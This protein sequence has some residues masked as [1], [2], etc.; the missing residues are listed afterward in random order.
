MRRS[1][2]AIYL[3]VAVIPLTPEARQAAKLE[4]SRGAPGRRDGVGSPAAS[5][6]IKPGDIILG[7]QGEPIQNPHDLTR[8]VAG[9][10]PG[11]KVALRVT[12]G[13]RETP[14][15]V[16]LGRL[17]DAPLTPSDAER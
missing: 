5:A 4:S 3:G 9:T 2:Q 11:A 6:G 12:R 8:R 10:P 15:E 16:T 1:I 14:V 13:G 17:K 7:F